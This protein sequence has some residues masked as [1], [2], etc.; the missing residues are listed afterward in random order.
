MDVFLVDDHRVFTDLLRLGLDACSDLRCSGV[1]HSIAEARAATV[2]Y[3]VAVVDLQLPDGSGLALVGPLQPVL[4]LTA[5]PHAA[6]RAGVA[7]VLGK[8]APLTEILAAIR[9]VAAGGVL[10]PAS[11]RPAGAPRL[12]PRELDVLAE[13]G[14]GRDAARIATALGLSLHTVRDHIRALMGKLGAHS[15]LEAVVTAGRLGLIAVGS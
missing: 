6:R 2:A 7:G 5:H 15:Q 13:L 3:D 8:D 10:P 9:T 14:R 1:A 11:D 12:T 4:L